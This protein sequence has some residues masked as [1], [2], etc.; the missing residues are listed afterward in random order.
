MEGLK[1]QEGMLVRSVIDMSEEEMGNHLIFPSLF[2]T[3]FFLSFLLFPN[4][5][6]ETNFHKIVR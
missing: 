1:Q 5:V 6:V 4:F 3:L 2:F